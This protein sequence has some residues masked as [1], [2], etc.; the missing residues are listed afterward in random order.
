MERFN[1]STEGTL[2]TYKDG[3]KATVLKVGHSSTR[4]NFACRLKSD[5]K[6]HATSFYVGPWNNR[7]LFKALSHATMLKRDLSLAKTK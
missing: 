3:L 5:P 6:I 7:N 4:W 2:I 1:Q